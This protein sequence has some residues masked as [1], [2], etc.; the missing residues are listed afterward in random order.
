M[1]SKEGASLQTISRFQAVAVGDVIYIHTHRSLQDILAIDVS[2]PDEPQLSLVPVSSAT[3]SP[4][5]A[6][7]TNL[8]VQQLPLS[9]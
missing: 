3:G 5:A 6:R 4:P 2:N 1:Q 9:S 8:L 7:Y